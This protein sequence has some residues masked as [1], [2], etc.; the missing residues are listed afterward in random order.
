[1]YARLVEEAV[2][3]LKNE[4]LMDDYE[5][6]MALGTAA[7]L[8]DSYAPDTRA[9]IMLYRR[10]SRALGDGEIAE[11]EEELI[12]RFGPLPPE[13]ENLLELSGMK[14]LAKSV[15]ARRLEITDQGVRISFFSDGVNSRA[16]VLEKVL[17][18]ARDP[19][20]RMTLTPDGELFVPAVNLKIKSYGTV[21][22]VRHF[23]EY[24]DAAD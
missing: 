15:R 9:R 23:L 16:D 6:E 3:E 20:R 19:V 18:L 21:G 13:A 22:S 7:Y 11:I 8:P 24:L 10:L 14:I 4:P 17:D 12:D 1:M 2:A 5:P